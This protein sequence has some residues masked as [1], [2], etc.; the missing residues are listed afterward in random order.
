M[1]TT[2]GADKRSV[3][4]IPFFRNHVNADNHKPVSGFL[5]SCGSTLCFR[6]VVQRFEQVASHLLE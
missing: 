5:A 3:I 2:S 1:F 6:E 4:L